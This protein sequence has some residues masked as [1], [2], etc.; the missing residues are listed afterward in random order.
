MAYQVQFLGR[1]EQIEAL[2]AHIST[3]SQRGSRVDHWTLEADP[4]Q[5][6]ETRVVGS[7]KVDDTVFELYRP[8]MERGHTELL[9]DGTTVYR[10]TALGLGDWSVKVRIKAKLAGSSTGLVTIA[11]GVANQDLFVHG[12]RG[13]ELPLPAGDVANVSVLA[14]RT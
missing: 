6:G 3:W 14:E 2:E 7:G 12:R 1:M 8:D 4:S 11:S 10:L 13:S 9:F 5:P